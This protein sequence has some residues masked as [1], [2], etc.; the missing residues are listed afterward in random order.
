VTT[1]ASPWSWYLRPNGWP[2]RIPNGPPGP[3]PP[4]ANEP[5][6][7]RTPHPELPTPSGGILGGVMSPSGFGG[8]DAL[9]ASSPAGGLLQ[10]LAQLGTGMDQSPDTGPRLFSPFAVVAGPYPPPSVRGGPDSASS[11]TQRDPAAAR[12]FDEFT[13]QPSARVPDPSARFV[14]RSVPVDEAVLAQAAR[15]AAAE[16]LGRR[17]RDAVIAHSAAAQSAPEEE[18]DEPSLRE[19]M[20]LNLSDAYYRGTLLGASRLAGLAHLAATPDEPGLDPDRKRVHDDLRREYQQIVADLAHY[21]RMRSSGSIGE[22]GASALGQF[23]GGLLSPEGWI[24][25]GAKGAEAA[26]RIVRGV[27]QQGALSG[28]IDPLLQAL[29]ISAGVQ[30]RYDPARNVSSAVGGAVTGGAL[31]GAHEAI[32]QIGTR[33]RLPPETRFDTSAHDWQWWKPSRRGCRRPE[34]PVR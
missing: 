30:E 29:N 25:A 27:L 12:F 26:G 5:L 21:D 15:A 18:T 20:R 33:W 2:Y 19:R 17:Y 1:Q 8:R 7:D 6:G 22:L 23:G 28:A 32:G 13:F 24:G 14:E 10:M 11:M 31:R 4:L 3:L 34:T 16:R 9:A